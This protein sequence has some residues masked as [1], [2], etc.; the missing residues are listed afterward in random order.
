MNTCTGP[1]RIDCVGRILANSEEQTK[2]ALFDDLEG[3]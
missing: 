2:T 1:V 3:S